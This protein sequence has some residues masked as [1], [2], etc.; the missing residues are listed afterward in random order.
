MTPMALVDPYSPCPCGSD[1]KFKW[2]CQK[3]ESYVERA[4]RLSENGQQDAALAALDEGLA[5]VPD[6]PWV[7][8]RKAIL[9]I[10]QQ[11]P[12]EAKQCVARVLEHQP[13]HLGAS[14]LQTRLVLA[15]EGPVAAASQFQ[16]ALLHTAAESRSR[17]VKIAALLGEELAKQ[18]HIQAALRHLELAIA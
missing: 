6:N 1:K 17:L 4:Y 5:K 14:V 7:L 3:V 16:H 11:Q 12:S 13:N 18:L 10:N 15:T 2:C 8:L 9:M